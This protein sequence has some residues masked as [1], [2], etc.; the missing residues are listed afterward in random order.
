MTTNELIESYVND[1]ALQLPRNQRDDVAFELRALLQEELQ[2]RADAAGRAADPALAIEL[3]RAFGRPGDVAARYRPGLTIIDPAD[4]RGFMRATL[5]GLA[6]IWLAGLVAVLQ[7]PIESSTALFGLLGRWWTGTVIPSLA[8]PGFLVL[9]FGLSSWAR[10]RWPQ[11]TTWTPHASDRIQ[12]GRI[13]LVLG[14]AGVLAGAYLLVNPHWVLDFF[15]NGRAAPAAYE[16]LTYTETFLGR[17]APC[18]LLLIL[19]NIP[20]MLIAL[21]KGRR[22]P[23]LQDLETGLALLNCVVMVWTILDGPALA[24]PF[25]DQVFKGALTLIA[26]LTLIHLGIERFQR[27]RPRPAF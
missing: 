21:L 19:L 18:L 2:A 12:G 4:G 16:A 10:H 3:L 26:T 25:G 9:C 13:G 22:P 23:A 6:I 14:M 11:D 8:W 27:I 1:V 5:I 20:L 17:Q 15:W 24:T 7:Q